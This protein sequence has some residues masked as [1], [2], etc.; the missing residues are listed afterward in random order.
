M[1]GVVV[2]GM[3]TA[4]GVGAGIGSTV[5]EGNAVAV[6]VG[7]RAI[8]TLEERCE[9]EEVEVQRLTAATAKTAK[10]ASPHFMAPLPPPHPGGLRPRTTLQGYAPSFDSRLHNAWQAFPPILA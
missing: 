7:V 4:V 1:A 6:A 2:G 10:A 9:V 8:A 3:T 5:G